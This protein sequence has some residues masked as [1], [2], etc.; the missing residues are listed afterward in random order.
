MGAR[1]GLQCNLN[2]QSPRDKCPCK[3]QQCTTVISNVSGARARKHQHREVS[4]MPRTNGIKLNAA[5]AASPDARKLLGPIIA[6]LFKSGLSQAQLLAECRSAVRRASASKLKIIHVGFAQE[7]TDIVNRWLRDPAYLNNAGRPDE[8]PLK[9]DRSI[10]SLVRACR[11][12]VTPSVALEMMVDFG[13]VRRV[14]S[15]KYRLI[16]RLMDFGHSKFLPFEPSFRFLLDATKVSTTRLRHSTKTPGLFWQCAD[17]SRIESRNAQ[18]FLRFAQ[19]RG[20]SF[21]HEINDWL[22]E[23]ER[24]KSRSFEKQVPLRRLGVGLFGI[25]Q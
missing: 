9:G 17:N 4:N 22:D 13:V 24:I 5:A 7:G 21:M 20:L 23:H 16:R 3:M 18:A 6:F 1:R 19:Q 2:Y 10:G 14:A 15:G 25:C 12:S 8:L 11:V